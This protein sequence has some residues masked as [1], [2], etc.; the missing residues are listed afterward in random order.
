MIV[1][2]AQL[3]GRL[4]IIK[5]RHLLAS[6]NRRLAHLVWVQ[7]ADVNVRHNAIL[8]KQAQEDHVFNTVLDV[9]LSARAHI[10]GLHPQHE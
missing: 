2:D 7:P 4:R 6:N 1:I 9:A 10:N 8:K 5:H 3:F